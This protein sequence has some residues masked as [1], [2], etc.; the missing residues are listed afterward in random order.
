MFSTQEPAITE[1]RLA[2]QSSSYVSE[3]VRA[4]SGSDEFDSSDWEYEPLGG[5]FG[6]A[7]GGT[8]LY[9]MVIRAS[10][11]RTCSLILKVLYERSNETTSS[12]YYWKREYEVYRSGML[13]DLPAGTFSTPRIYGLQDF[14]DSC[15]IWMEE[16]EDR[17]SQWSLDDFHDIAFR[18]GQM[19]GA[20]LTG[21]VSPSFDWLS[22][23]WHSA[24]VPALADAFDNLDELL[25]NPLARRA[26][27]VEAKDEIL[28][29]WR[30]RQLFQNALA[31]LPKT[32]CHTDAFRRNILHRKDDI[33]LLDWALASI[34]SIGEELVCL[35]A[36]SLYYRGYS[37]AFA[38][39]LDKTAFAGY[40]EGL[41]HAGWNGD[42]KLAR[43][44]YTCGMVLRGLAGVK[45]D[46]QLLLDR[47]NH[48]Q[49]RQ[50]HGMTSLHDIA[51]LFADVRR[52]R[53]LR[54]AQ[55]ARDLLQR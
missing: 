30:D 11:G 33:V 19:N 25:V 36:V 47:A 52:F 44:G 7:V 13:D 31:Q 40:V 5:G 6:S 17:K 39:E 23:N 18:L 41:R 9:R 16:I 8:A 50:T 2:A 54:M 24:I 42:R 43:I 38:E 53:L 27:P 4:A 22:R 21:S 55:E 46:L 1:N 49:I 3:L 35:V 51:R 10:S 12:P 29:I 45:Q 20:G 34:G 26:L 28:A 15:W 37:A 48:E 32:L 14:G